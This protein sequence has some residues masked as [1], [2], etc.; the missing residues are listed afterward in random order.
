MEYV[1]V[2]NNLLESLDFD[3][4]DIKS[5][6]VD[7]NL[8]ASLDFSN[9]NNIENISANN[10][11]LTSLS[12]SGLSKL[13]DLRVRKN[14][15]TI[16][17]LDSCINL[18]KLYADSNNITTIRNLNDC[19]LLEEMN[20]ANNQ[21]SFID[22][23]KCTNL[24]K[25]WYYNNNFS[26][27]SCDDLYCILPQRVSGARGT[28]YPL[29]NS[30]DINAS[31][32]Q[33]TNSFNAS[34]KKWDVKFY[35]NNTD[36]ITSGSHECG[37]PSGLPLIKL[38]AEK[39]GNI[40]LGFKNLSADTIAWIETASGVF[41]HVNIGSTDVYVN[42]EISEKDVNIYGKIDYFD[43]SN[44]SEADVKITSID[45]QNAK[46]L[47]SLT[48]K[49]N[50]I[51]DIDLSKS[52]KLE[53]LN[54]G[55]N[56]LSSLNIFNSPMLKSLYC[57]KNNFTT[58]SLDELYCSLPQRL[59]ADKGLI[60]P[61]Y[62]NADE[63][64]QI[65][66]ATT[67]ENA[68]DK[69]WDVKFND[70]TTI[71]T[72]GNNPCEVGVISNLIVTVVENNAALT[73]DFNAPEFGDT[74]LY[75]DFDVSLPISWKTVDYDGDAYSWLNTK[76][77]SLYG[78]IN[79]FAY[80]GDNAVFSASKR[81][82]GNNFIS[83]TPTNWLISPAIDG[84]K[85]ISYMI[86]S[87]VGGANADKDKIEILTSSTTS[88]IDQ[89]NVV[90]KDSCDGLYNV[91]S[92]RNVNLPEGTKYIAFKHCNSENQGAVV[93][94]NITF[95]DTEYN[96]EFVTYNVYRN[97]V[98]I[99]TT[100]GKKYFDSK[101]FPSGIYEYCVKAVKKD[102]SESEKVCQSVQVSLENIVK[103]Q[104]AIFPN[105]ASNLLYVISENANEL[106]TISDLSGKIVHSEK[107]NEKQTSINVS[108]LSAGMY[109]V[110][111]GGKV[112]KFVK[113]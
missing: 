106:I 40:N 63:N 79:V 10:N 87:Q 86:T 30:S 57:Y 102:G 50:L 37:L 104:A 27:E 25:L 12:V 90:A 9:C 48:C 3:N 93:L 60:C 44:V 4:C 46:D 74:I 29:F 17:D 70:E 16:L 11:F 88:E 43:C 112:T 31:V 95:F 55:N 58:Q 100:K 110:R 72:N 14:Q 103:S 77:N 1:S 76:H 5:I 108:Q 15:L 47:I 65:I 2:N 73:W 22:V 105:P 45:V 89:F 82:D 66:A 23:S 28:I 53:Y 51:S 19:V 113:E 54:F 62:D 91:W 75:E 68:I 35:E 41:R 42:Y 38:T 98:L 94:D 71:V 36:I 84:A 49:N 6:Y 67:S 52:I 26:V 111:V 80:Q 69:N 24:Y 34:Y 32:I 56:N 20:V 109:I 96:S 61:A 59:S 83:L 107:A 85:N 92:E 97:D 18:R 39:T 64:F 8:F 21:I 33:Q 7:N 13:T 101:V 99:G 81:N 78:N